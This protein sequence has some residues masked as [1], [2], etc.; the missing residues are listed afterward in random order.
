MIFPDIN[1]L[2]YAYDSGS[3]HHRI[4]SEWLE[5]TINGHIPVCFSWHTIFGFMRVATTIR[6]V[7]R[8][9]TAPEAM[10]IAEELMSAATAKMLE[11]GENTLGYFAG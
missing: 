5:T 7:S 8:P 9:F 11:P 4:C 1:L 10:T 3:K 6:M 2:I